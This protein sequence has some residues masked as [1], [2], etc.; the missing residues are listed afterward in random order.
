LGSDEGAKAQPSN[1]PTAEVS[2]LSRWLAITQPLQQTFNPPSPNAVLARAWIPLVLSDGTTIFSYGDYAQV[3]DQLAFLLPFDDSDAPR[4]EAVSLPRAAVDLEATTR[5]S[6]SVRAGRYTLTQGPREF[7]GLSQEVSIALNSVPSRPDPLARV[8]LIEGVLRR[9]IEWPAA[10]YGYRARDVNEAVSMLEPILSQFRAAA[11][12]NRI[13]LSLVA[14]TSAPLPPITFRQPTLVDLIENAMR[15]VSVLNVPAE[16]T[17][18]LRTTAASLERHRGDLPAVWLATGQRRVAAAL[19][20]EARIDDAYRRL[21]TDVITGAVRAAA[22]GNVRAISALQSDLT[23]RDRRLGGKRQDV[24][25]STMAALQ[26][27]YDLAARVQLQRDQRTLGAEAV[28]AYANEVGPALKRFDAVKADLGQFDRISTASPKMSALR[29]ALEFV[30][31]T[32]AQCPPPPQLAG[33]HGLLLTAA[34]LAGVAV[35]ESVDPRLTSEMADG[36]RAS[37]AAESLAMFDRGRRAIEA[38]RQTR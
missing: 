8:E 26:T 28:R 32:L 1:A 36:V 18:V 4:V 38:A 14:P 27:Q 24:L 37:A 19:K 15:L 29:D 21:S 33:S 11:H 25:S 35:Q 10:H 7:A 3:D 23:E 12:V 31:R 2:L 17:A 20:S 6:E 22:D 30:K 34:Y 13:D 5:A 9:L 16:R